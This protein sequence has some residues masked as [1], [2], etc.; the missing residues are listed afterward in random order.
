MKMIKSC[1]LAIAVC[2]FPVAVT[3]QISPDGSTSTTVDTNGNVS[4]IEGGEEAGGNLF[5]S[6]S[7]FSVLNGNEAYFNNAANIDNIL[8]RVTGGNVSNIDG[9]IRANGSANL[10]LINP[11]GILFNGGARLDLG[12][13]FYGST[14]DSILFPQGV[15][16]SA[17]NPVAP[18]L[19]IDAPIGLNLRNEPG[20]IAVNN[21]NM[22]GVSRT[23]P[24]PSGGRN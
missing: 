14:A 21:S 23:K 7:D 3:A 9:L 18:V 12:G 22:G 16:F 6:F 11:A 15:E 10:F 13:S 17:S 5:H 19:T 4:T 24:E 2:C 20:S 1:S 8:S